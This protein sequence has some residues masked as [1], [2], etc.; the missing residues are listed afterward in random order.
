MINGVFVFCCVLLA[1]AEAG[2]ARS[3]YRTTRHDVAHNNIVNS[4]TKFVFAFPSSH[5]NPKSTTDIEKLSITFTNTDQQRAATVVVESI[6]KGFQTQK[7]SVPANSS[8]TIY[9]NPVD[10]Q[11]GYRYLKPT[12]SVV[13]DKG[14]SITSDIPVIALAENQHID[15][16]S[17]DTFTIFPI[18]NLGNTYKAV[19]DMSP[20]EKTNIFTIVAIEDGTKVTFSNRAGTITRKLGRLQALTFQSSEMITTNN[21]ISA[22]KNIAVISGSICGYGFV[23]GF[24]P[25]NQEAIMLLPVSAWGKRYPFAPFSGAKQFEFIALPSA[26][27]TYLTIGD[28]PGKKLSNNSYEFDHIESNLIEGDQPIDVIAVGGT[29]S[30]DYFGAPFF[31]HIPAVEQYINGTVVINTG[32]D[33]HDDKA[34]MHFI[35]LIQILWDFDS[36]ITVNGW[37]VSGLIYT[38][39]G[40]TNYYYIDYPVKNGEHIVKSKNKFGCVVYGYGEMIGYAYVPRLNLPS[41]GTC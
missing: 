21:P 17:S 7:T 36:P 19:G 15:G 1:L 26:E 34:S 27:F 20:K 31:T 39:I 30:P 3:V 13:E 12:G 35:R 38:R 41:T 23:S 40:R 9:I 4:G 6:F 2:K 22:D 16:G 29:T 18:C 5:I 28:S 10:I 14:I 11:A 24:T 25:C 33:E 32:I 8:S 37:P